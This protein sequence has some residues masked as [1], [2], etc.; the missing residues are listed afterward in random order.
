MT[1][2]LVGEKQARKE[3]RQREVVRAIKFFLQYVKWYAGEIP[4][5]ALP[6]IL[7]KFDLKLRNHSKQ[8]LFLDLLKE[9]DWVYVRADYS[10]P[11]RHGGDGGRAR[12]YGIGKAMAGKFSGYVPENT[13]H[14]TYGPIYMSPTF[15][16]TL[17]IVPDMPSFD[18]Q[19]SEIL[20]HELPLA[21]G[22]GG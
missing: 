7:K 19:L 3:N 20:G 18:I 10:H 21:T 14:R 6:V 12:A 2:I 16:E 22:D 5:S 15:S 8:Q 13:P 4:V 1:P 17:L 9:W 11:A